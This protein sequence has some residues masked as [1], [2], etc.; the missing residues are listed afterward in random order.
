MSNN[1]AF[2]ET[3]PNHLSFLHLNNNNENI[4]DIKHFVNNNSNSS[5]NNN[6]LFWNNNNTPKI[7]FVN[8]QQT[9]QN[10]NMTDI[11]NKAINFNNNIDLSVFSLLQSQQLK[12]AGENDQITNTGVVVNMDKRNELLQRKAELLAELANID[13]QLNIL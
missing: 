8:F 11:F 6:N 1:I 13:A 3:V 5:N 10:N 7:N 9:I 2:G 4:V 12:L